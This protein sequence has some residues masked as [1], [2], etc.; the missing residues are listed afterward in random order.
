VKRKLFKRLDY[1]YSLTIV[2][3]LWI[4]KKIVAEPHGVGPV[5]PRPGYEYAGC[6][7]VVVRA[8]WRQDPECRSPRGEIQGVFAWQQ[9]HATPKLRLPHQPRLLFWFSFTFWP[10]QLLLFCSLCSSVAQILGAMVEATSHWA[11]LWRGQ[12]W[13][14][15]KLPLSLRSFLFFFPC[16]KFYLI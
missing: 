11:W 1:F 13:L 3:E 10:P 2:T 4:E 16:R 5:G 9:K 14:G 15:I 8:R 6:L 7:L 12:H